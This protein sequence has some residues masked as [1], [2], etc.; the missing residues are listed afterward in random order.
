MTSLRDDILAE[1]SKAQTLY[2]IQRIGDDATAF[3]ELMQLFLHDDYRVT[4]RAAW[5]LSYCLEKHPEWAEAYLS[6]LLRN[7]QKPG[8]HDAVK[9]NTVR[10]LQT[11]PVPEELAGEAA[12][13]LIQ[14][15]A[16]PAEPLAVRCFSMTA[17]FN[18]AKKEA[19]LLEEL[20]LVVEDVLANETAGS[21]HARGKRVLKDIQKF[22]KNSFPTK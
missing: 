9:R 8:I 4:Q 20:R 7:L 13:M 14:Y 16:N 10:A 15:I 11:V 5:P 19:D 12:E 22:K 1:H 6:E 2:I 17:F 21:L 18:L 3:D